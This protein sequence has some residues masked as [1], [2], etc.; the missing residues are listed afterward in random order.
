MTV[1]FLPLSAVSSIFGMNT[2]DIRDMEQGQWA[3]WA[4]AIPVTIS[5]IFLG[6]LFTG[7]LGNLVEW[8]LGRRNKVAGYEGEPFERLGDRWRLG[9]SRTSDDSESFVW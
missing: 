9:R 8:A 6:L 3:Y 4:A 1:V 2:A 7:E 5:V